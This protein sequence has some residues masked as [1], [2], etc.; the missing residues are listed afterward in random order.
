[1][2]DATTGP[3]RFQ[4][5]G[6]LRVTRGGTELDPGA[7]QPRLV[8]ALLLARAGALVGMR[9]LAELLWAGDAPASAANVVHR[10][11][12]ALRRVLE[13]GLAARDA[14]RFISR[15]LSGYQLS[16]TGHD[17]DLLRFRADVRQAR[18]RT[19][20]GDH[21]RALEDYLSALT[22]WQGR[23]AT[24]LEPAG[25][26]HPA[27][28]GIE[29][30]RV[31]AVRDATDAATRTGE[32]RRVLPYLLQAAEH[33]PLDETLQ[34]GLLRAYT[35]DGRRAE[36]IETFRAV[37]ERLRDQ[38]GVDPGP[39]LRHAYDAARRR[40]APTTITAAATAPVAPGAVY[41]PAQLPP[42]QPF[43]AGRGDLVARAGRIAGQTGPGGPQVIAIDGMP[44]VGKTTLAVRLAHLLAAGYPDGQLYVDLRG[45]DR[46]GSVMSPGEALRGFLGALGIAPQDVPAE[47]HAQAGLF[48]SALAGKRVLI[49]LDNCRDSEH[50]RD[51]LPGAPGCLVL[52]TSRNRLTGLL[53]SSG[54]HPLPLG[55]P[56]AVE[57]REGLSRR[58]GAE[59]VG[60]EPGAVQRIIES[61][62][63][64]PLALAVV[65][66][67]AAGSPDV[68][69]ER[70]AGEL[71]AA[72]GSLDGFDSSDPGTDLRVVFSWS[73]RALSH[74][75]ARLFRLM[76]AHPV[77]D[78][79]IAAAA[80]LT[81][82]PV[83]AARALIGELNRAHLIIE[84]QPGRYRTHDLLRA[85]AIE[86]SAEHDTAAE[87]E[88]AAAG[89]GRFYRASAYAAHRHLL[90]YPVFEPLTEAGGADAG[91]SFAG[92]T[93]AMRWFTAEQPVLTEL[94]RSAAADGRAGDAWRLALAMQQHFEH[95]GRWLDWAATAQVAL[96]G[97]AIADDLPGQARMH[98]SLAGA[99]YFLRRFDKAVFH[100]E[101]GRELLT[102]LGLSGELT[103]VRINLAMIRREQGRH[104]D[105]IAELAGMRRGGAGK[106]RAD[107]LVVMAA[108]ST[109]LGLHDQAGQLARQAMR[110]F[111]GYQDLSG[112]GDAW[113]V[114]GRMHHHRGRTD[115]AVRAWREAAGAYR[116]AAADAPAADALALIGDVLAEGDDDAA[117]T[118]VWR[119][120]LA[121]VPDGRSPVAR[122]IRERVRLLS[123]AR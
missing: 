122:A 5:L 26:T 60:A 38:L 66:A 55:L 16:V 61:C 117:A 47:P 123:P 104:A 17:V 78:L 106:Q 115:E 19:R 62:G 33:H 49:V 112:I 53:T 116:G 54:A 91:L 85:Y 73:Y 14:G 32:P 39:E 109:A 7:R 76:P 107:A 13:P 8:L 29:A 87:R 120:A 114:L 27:F 89:A 82:V 45:F 48:R 68:P 15:R 71:A 58:I 111:E 80:A 93:E 51:L 101:R 50:V 18:E 34:A 41:R 119:E 69:L 21:G 22:L 103:R 96:Q 30:E 42:D 64:L 10:Q 4:L 108:S 57:A 65:A 1:M 79:S 37:R 74:G 25:H 97:A 121:L 63:R 2:R 98:R 36:A 94:V 105:A 70:I 6:P 40:A 100:L 20:A 12:G 44:G 9:D 95:S 3:V 110:I 102:E 24:G 59:R 43:F 92:R 81:G 52:V 46:Q 83:R 75:A 72:Q 86:L 31:R 11:V 35:A 84:R 88:R 99:H 77:R 23:C 90:A 56:T 113:L 118:E 67:R 28:T